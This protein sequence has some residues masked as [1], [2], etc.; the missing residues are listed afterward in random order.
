MNPQPAVVWWQRLQPLWPNGTQ[1]HTGDAGALAR[2]RR[3]EL[4]DVAMQPETIELYQRL[5]CQRPAQLAEVALCAGAL[6]HVRDNVAGQSTAQV[7]AEAGLSQARFRSLLA[8]ATPEE[9]LDALRRALAVAGGLANVR[10]LARA[11]LAW[12]DDMLSRWAIDFYSN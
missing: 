12:D 7:L 5:G 10:D 9:R 3:G 6:A 11:C 4:R 8:T 2:L 1:N